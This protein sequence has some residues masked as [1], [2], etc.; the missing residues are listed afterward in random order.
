[1]PYSRHKLV[2]I[3]VGRKYQCVVKK[4]DSGNQVSPCKKKV[5][6][7]KLVSTAMGSH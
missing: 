2:M 5:V 7:L 1:M 4:K 6:A 3:R